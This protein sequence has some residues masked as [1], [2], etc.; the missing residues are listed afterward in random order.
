V[1]ADWTKPNPSIAALLKE[2]GQAA[3]P[4]YLLFPSD[5]NAEPIRLPEGVI[6]SGDV[7]EAIE[8]LPN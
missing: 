4:F 6:T 1:I 7:I 2:Y 8:K 3:I 5:P